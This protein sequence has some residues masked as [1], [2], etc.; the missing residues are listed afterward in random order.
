MVAI[1]ERYL[2]TEQVG[3][4]LGGVK[5]STIYKLMRGDDFPQGVKVGG[6]TRW[7]E[8]EIHEWVK[9]QNPGHDFKTE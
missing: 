2:N 9:A 3:E 8:S 1:T 4:L 7:L 5:R 6:A